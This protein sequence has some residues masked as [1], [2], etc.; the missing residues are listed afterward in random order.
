MNSSDHRSIAEDLK[1][2]LFGRPNKRIS[3]NKLA[4]FVSALTSVLF[5]AMVGF[6]LIMI[7]QV[8]A[9]LNDADIYEFNQRLGIDDSN[10]FIS[11]VMIAVIAAVMNWYFAP[12]IIPA[13]CFFI[14][15][16]TG[17]LPHRGISK[18]SKY[19]VWTGGTGATL[20]GLTS[21]IGTVI[22]FGLGSVDQPT[23]T[24]QLWRFIGAL[25][26]GGIIGYLA[27]LIVGFIHHLIVRPQSQLE[28][29]ELSTADVF[30]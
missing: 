20:V 14:A 17:R 2:G 22:V 29:N 26:M 13:A 16:T 12:I 25:I 24:G 9:I 23:P 28:K 1:P 15:Q 8:L 3:R 10:P 19:L 21:A 30:N 5:V 4:C 7:W 6:L 18:R 27:G 11:G